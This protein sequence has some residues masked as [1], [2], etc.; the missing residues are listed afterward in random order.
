MSGKKKKE[1]NKIKKKAT[2]KPPTYKQ[3]QRTNNKTIFS[4]V[5][6]TKVSNTSL[7]VRVSSHHVL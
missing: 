6:K 1:K 2:E 3:H 7:L 5:K 4:W